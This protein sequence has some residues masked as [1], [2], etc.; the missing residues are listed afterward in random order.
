MHHRYSVLASI[1]VGSLLGACSKNDSA[2]N[3]LF[4]ENLNCPAPGQ[5]E[6]VGWGESGTEH[7]CKIK[8]GPFVAFE[9]GH[10]KVRG[11]YDMGKEVGTWRWYGA[12]GKVEREINYSAQPPAI[13]R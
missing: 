6:F 1:L 3:E 2:S 9:N 11:Q 13:S 4:N 12:D 8:H 10:V 5:E 7:V